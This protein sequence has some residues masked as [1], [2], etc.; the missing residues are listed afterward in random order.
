MINV[1]QI[2]Q[3]FD[4][5][6]NAPQ[7]G[8][9]T[10]EMLNILINN[11]V[12]SLYKQRL[13]I[14][15]QADFGTAI[16]KIAYARTKK[17]HHDLKPYR[18]HVQIVINGEYIDNSNL[19][20]DLYFETSI[21]YYTT[22]RVEDK[23]KARKLSS[24]GCHKTEEQSDVDYKYVKYVGSL[25]LIEEDKWANR[26][27]S[28]LIK[29]AIYLPFDDG[30]KLH[31]PVQK[32]SYIVIEYLKRPTKAKWN[33][34]YDSINE[35]E[36]YSQAGSVNVEFDD[37]LRGEIVGRMVKEYGIYT[38]DNKSIQAGQDVINNGA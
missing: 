25:E 27:N 9:Y 35:V 2:K 14:P 11:A 21:K 16:P 3:G 18:K 32:P 15:E 12:E 6:I 31:F 24:C 10:P 23:D 22:I 34:V 13:G 33:W 4:A 20:E 26:V 30:F 1:N 8:N 36:V 7:Q 17:I 38:D 28:R 5:L 37:L 29:Q 19:P